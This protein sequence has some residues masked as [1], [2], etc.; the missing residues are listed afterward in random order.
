[1]KKSVYLIMMFLGL[2]FTSCE[3]M[4]DIHDQVDQAIE[5]RPISGITEYTLTD[6]DYA[7]LE[8]EY[9]SFNSL[10]DAGSLIPG[11]LDENF[12]VWGQGS[13]AQVTFDLY[14]PIDPKAYLVT[15][16]DYASVGLDVNYFTN[17]SKIKEF[18]SAKYPQAATNEYV[19]L[20]YRTVAVDVAYT[21]TDDDFDL[22][23]DSFDAIY[24][25]PAWSAGNY[26]NFERREDD[27]KYWSNDMILEALNVVLEKKY[28]GIEGQTYEISYT[29]YDGNSGTESMKL[30]YDG[31]SYVVFGADNFEMQYDDYKIVEAA[32]GDKYPDATSNAAQFG[33]FTTVD[34][35]PNFWSQDMILEAINVVLKDYF[36][37]ANEGN[38]VNVTYK[39]YLGGGKTDYPTATVSL[40]DGN[41]V[42]DD[43]V[44]ISTI[45]ETQVYAHGDGSWMIPL[46]LPGDIYKE[47]FEQKYNNF[48]SESDAGFYI[49]R[50]LEPLYPYAMEGDFISVAYDY[51]SGG[52]VTR[53]ASFIYN[54]REWEFIPST[55]P[56]TLQFGHE[57]T[58]WV[59]DNTITYTL[60]TADYELIGSEFEDIYVDPAWSVGNYQNFDR[61]DGNRNQWKD[62]MLLEAM[63][64]LLDQ[65]VAPNA[66]VGQKYLLTFNIYDGNSG[67]EQMHLIKTEDGVWIPV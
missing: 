9:G 38:K 49:G 20:T 2:A 18:L 15:E 27:E 8:L 5:S 24:P 65:K 51:Y 40:N 3:P 31:T 23:S 4:E 42:W 57:G 43:S 33:S 37:T 19:E 66:E 22:I 30:R 10:E 25:D 55:I 6:E 54:D 45:M 56:F 48:G 64:V 36:P 11:L 32:L 16:D 39:V 26:S 47:E 59:V 67:T 58:G 13:L 28:D 63:N 53:Y 21:L 17:V 34:D 12:P 35:D 60:S 7:A 50:Y 41:Y 1:M 52:L 62:D 29:I 61:R 46:T 14:A 44:T